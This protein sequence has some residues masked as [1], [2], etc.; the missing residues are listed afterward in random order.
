[1]G[2]AASGGRKPVVSQ[3]LAGQGPQDSVRTKARVFLEKLDGPDG[4]GTEFS[5]PGA[6]RNTRP[7]ESGLNGS[8]FRG[9]ISPLVDVDFVKGHSKLVIEKDF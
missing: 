9:R 5:V 3:S 6:R 4:P 2:S 1:M 8:R 7:A